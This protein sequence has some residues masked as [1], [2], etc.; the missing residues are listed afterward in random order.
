MKVKNNSETPLVVADAV[1]H[2]GT[3]G[4]VRG[5]V[6]ARLKAER[7]EFKGLV[8]SKTYEE[9]LLLPGD[10]KFDCPNCLGRG[11][12][13]G[14]RDDGTP[15]GTRCGCVLL[16][17]VMTNVTKIWP[18][19]DLN[20]VG[21]LSK[22]TRSP[23]QDYGNRNLY[24][25]A[26]EPIFKMH[27]RHTAVR[28][29]S[30]WGARVHADVSLF[31]AWFFTAKAKGAEI[32]DVNVRDTPLSEYPSIPE[33]VIPPDLL[34]L[35][36]GV[37]NSRNVA[38]PELLRETLKL[39][40]FAGKPTWVVDQPNQIVTESHHLFYSSE[41]KDWLDT[42]N[43]VTLDM[44]RTRVQNPD[45]ILE[46][47]TPSVETR[48]GAEPGGAVQAPVAQGRPGKFKASLSQH[49]GA[50][51]GSTTSENIVEPVE[52]WT[53]NKPKGNK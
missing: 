40:D 36:M 33:M 23:L 31:E 30:H 48:E 39:R 26:S 24:V 20:R 50:N 4:E 13:V 45:E 51:R 49:H 9:L 10:G 28:Q 25:T 12:I 42:W 6:W 3:V 47:F 17:D 38:S 53:P 15:S 43:H 2:P 1:V 14:S 32:Y 35:L 27:L 34:I 5:D 41:N 46:N 21:R 16:K 44:A 29:G 19:F 11:F 37:K 22:G 18:Q 7:P 8:D 52:K